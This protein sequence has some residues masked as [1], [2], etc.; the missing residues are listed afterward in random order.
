MRQRHRPTRHPAR[1]R[2]A[3]LLA[4]VLLAG[5]TPLLAPAPAA[6]IVGG[7]PTPGGEFAYVAEVRNTTAGALCTG[8]LIHPSWVLTAAHCA[9]PVSVGDV[10]VR[11]GN[12]VS[13]TGGETRRITRIVAHPQYI[14]GH[15][16][17]A[18]L[19]LSSPVTTITP[20]RLS[21]PSQAYLWDGTQGGPFTP[22][23]QGVAVG[24][25][26]DGTGNLPTRLQFVGVFITPPQ[27]DNLGIKRIMVDRGPCQGDSGGPLLVYTG[28]EYVQ[29]GVLKAASCTGIGSYSEV[30][31]GSNRTW[32]LNQLTALPYTTFGAV[33]WDRDGHAD[34]VTR[35]E[36]TGELWLY[37]GQS[38][39]GVSTADRARI[40]IGWRGYSFFGAGD[41][42]ADGHADILTRNDTTG[43]LW[44]Y[45]GQS[46]RGYST[47][48]PVRIGWGW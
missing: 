19:E 46:R 22:Y 35:Q 48:T 3:T 44:L 10:S 28:G 4:T 39:R 7:Q 25:G 45:A 1:R 5:L 12:N 42:D 18:L 14:G 29:A 8:S 31:A 41:W 20:V 21:T 47:E 6:A 26:R 43:D 11:I 33:D 34:I 38:R 32:L 27:P 40:G 2:L 15:N 36:A 24:W 17:L 13:N 9:V 16:D 23:D 30:G 37:P